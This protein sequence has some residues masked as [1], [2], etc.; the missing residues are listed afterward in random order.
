MRNLR[1]IVGLACVLLALGR[2]VVEPGGAAAADGPVYSTQD[3]VFADTQAA[4]CENADRLAAVTALFAR[5]GAADVSVVP[6]GKT[7]NVVVTIRGAGPGFLVV[8]AHYDK[9]RVGCGAVDNWSGVVLLAHVYKTFRQLRPNRTILFVAFGEEEAGLKGS[10]AMVDAISKADRPQYCAM[11]NLDSF[12]LARPQVLENTTTP[13]LR[14]FVKVVAEQ[15][16]VPIATASLE[17][18]A[19]ADS[20]SFKAAG[21][22]AV[23]LHGLPADWYR[24]I[25]S[26]RDEADQIRSPSMYLGYILALNLLGRLDA[27]E[28]GAFR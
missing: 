14:D 20:S 10:K 27:C 5:C 11:V 25:H 1:A 6:A 16:K 9:V 3:E 13:K 26:E 28:C 17:G 24:I 19:D 22:P 7:K 23:T 15:C 4:P 12:G 21:I 2:T 8:G 18:V